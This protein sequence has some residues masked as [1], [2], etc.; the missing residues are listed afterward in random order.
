M[1][2]NN[3]YEQRQ[4]SIWY[5]DYCLKN[6]KI[7]EQSKKDKLSWL[8]IAHEEIKEVKKL[9]RLIKKLLNK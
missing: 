8:S 4:E 3:L 5:I 6:A 2:I 1:D 9:N 7:K